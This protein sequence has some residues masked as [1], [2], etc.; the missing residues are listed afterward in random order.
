MQQIGYFFNLILVWP[1]TTVL[2]AL[3]KS[4]VFIHVPYAL[5]F[6]IIILTVIIRL[7][8]YPLI[9]SQLKASK[10]MQEIIPHVN[11]LKDKHKGDAKMLQQET[12]RLYK[13]HGVNPAAGCLPIFIQ[14]PIIWA[15]YSVL[16]QIVQVS[17][18]QAVSYINKNVYFAS[19]LKINSGSW[20]QTFFG[21]PLGQT[22]SQLLPTIG[23][24]IILVPVITG[25]F[26]FIQSKMMFPKKEKTEQDK[27]KKQDFATAFQSQSMYIFPVMIAFFS[28]S[29][30]IGLSL[31][32]NTFTL[33]GIIQ[34]YQI[35]G[36]GGLK[37]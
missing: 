27:N 24:L 30:P 33:F 11:K 1:I 16:Q 26:Q 31:Y 9:S 2:I 15:L 34:Q 28:Y 20:D 14:L 25:A 37:R 4:L 6:S 21:L 13:E 12:M 3:Y 32:W 35:S 8:L 17:P 5:G 10:K 29:F 7:I 19:F 23:I 22:P 18:S 36:W